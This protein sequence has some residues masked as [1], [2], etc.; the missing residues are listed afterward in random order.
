VR[1]GII[2]ANGRTDVY[3]K[4]QG[5]KGLRLRDD[6]KDKGVK[7]LD[8]WL[9]ESGGFIPLASVTGLSKTIS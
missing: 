8:P 7:D 4:Q 3:N 1:I 6:T 9:G 2:S 5:Q